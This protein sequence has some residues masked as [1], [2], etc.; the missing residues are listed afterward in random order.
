M[1]TQFIYMDDQNNR[2]VIAERGGY[3]PLEEKTCI[4][5]GGF[6]YKVFG[7]S[8]INLDTNIL[9]VLVWDKRSL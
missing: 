8:G 7:V 2:I 4:W 9:Q 6:I 5:F 1:K 3:Y